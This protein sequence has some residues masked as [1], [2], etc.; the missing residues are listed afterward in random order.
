MKKLE[1]AIQKDEGLHMKEAVEFVDMT[2]EFRSEIEVEKKEVRMVSGKS[3]L[4]IIS[5]I[6]RK[7]DRLYVTVQGEDEEK[8][9]EAIQKFFIEK[10]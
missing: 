8:A 7:G 2:E 5:L 9:A 6:A 3:L 4:G 1:Y 10:L